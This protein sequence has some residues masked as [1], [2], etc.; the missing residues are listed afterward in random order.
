MRHLFR[1]SQNCRV[2][3]ARTPYPIS[4]LTEVQ[5]DDRRQKIK[6]MSARRFWYR[7]IR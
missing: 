5:G 6:R 3:F 1:R 4:G 2:K 7:P